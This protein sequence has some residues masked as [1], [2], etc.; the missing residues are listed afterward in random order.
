[1]TWDDDIANSNLENYQ[2]IE[3]SPRKI[4]RKRSSGLVFLG[5]REPMLPI[6]FARSLK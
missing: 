3:A 4:P 2:P 1:M 5:E 6:F